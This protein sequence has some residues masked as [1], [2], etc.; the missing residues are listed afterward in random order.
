MRR[1]ISEFLSDESG[2]TA[3]EYAL[4]ATG[5]SIVILVAVNA[6]GAKLDGTLTTV[7]TSLK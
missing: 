4:I 3:I 6:I 1:L 7:N 5:I 2:A